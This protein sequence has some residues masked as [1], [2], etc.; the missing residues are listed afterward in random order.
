[1]PE[2][3][4]DVIA[5]LQI[6]RT[7]SAVAESIPAVSRDITIMALRSLFLPSSTWVTPR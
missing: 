6:T 4:G 7:P 5:F 3:A 1:M 2:P